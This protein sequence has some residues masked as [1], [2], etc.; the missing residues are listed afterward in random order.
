MR[1][2]LVLQCIGTLAEH[3]VVKAGLE[4]GVLLCSDLMFLVSMLPDLESDN[5]CGS[6]GVRESR[7]HRGCQIR[8]LQVPHHLSELG[9]VLGVCTA[10]VADNLLGSLDILIGVPFACCIIDVPLEGR[11]SPFKP[12]WVIRLA[13]VTLKWLKW[14]SCRLLPRLALPLVEAAIGA[15]LPV[16][17]PVDMELLPVCGG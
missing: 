17:C 6:R 9:R 4:V 3:Y 11:L 12:G 7:A 1:L 16:C 13:L 8:E 5:I 10:C 2:E 15:V 14:R